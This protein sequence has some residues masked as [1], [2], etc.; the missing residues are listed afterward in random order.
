MSNLKTDVEQAVN[1]LKGEKRGGLFSTYI[2]FIQFPKYRNFQKDLRV[3][4]S[5]PL[6]VVVGQNGTGKSSLLQAMYGAPANLTPGQWWFGTALDPTS[7]EEITSGRQRLKPEDKGSFWYQYHNDGEMKQAVKMRIRRPGDPDYWEP[8]RPIKSFGMEIKEGKKRDPVI[9]M[10]AI[11]MNFKSQISAF[12]RC[13]YFNSPE[14]IKRVENSG[15]WKTILLSAKRRSARIQDYLRWRSHKL[16]RVLVGG[17]TVQHWNAD[18]H[19]PRV[20]LSQEELDDIGFI[21]GRRYTSG[22]LVEHRF[23]ETWGMSVMFNTDD[24]SYSDAF[25]G[26]GESAVVR[27]VREVYSSEPGRLLL[28]DEPETSLH[29]GAQERLL[30]FLLRKASEKKLQIVVSTHSPAFVRSLP[31]EAIRVLSLTGNGKVQ[32]AE[33][34]N[35]DEAFYVLGHPAENV[36]QLI[37]EDRLTKQLI[38][39]VL[40]TMEESFRSQFITDFRPGGE[41][42]IKQDA[43][44]FMLEP[45]VRRKLLFDGDK[46]ETVLKFERATIN[47]DHTS[48][49]IDELIKQHFGIKVKYRQNSQMSEDEKRGLR[50]AFIDFANDCFR[51]VPFDTPEDAIWSDDRAR[52]LLSLAGVDHEC[53]DEIESSK[54]AKEKFERLARL[55][56]PN[57]FDLTGGDIGTIHRVFIKAFC[58][59]SGE[60]V[61]SIVALLKE[62]ADGA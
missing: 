21:V 6:T 22:Y 30:L 42:A 61:V 10:D 54:S 26:S 51:C 58:Q 37:V 18:F 19:K 31:K 28:L 59:E 11:Y 44:L 39:A 45:E 16:K 60:I 13:F 7:E 48:D 38:D 25:A 32:V 41:S 29:P 50:F 4:F 9:A 1:R 24:L 12:D 49:E 14:A 40:E 8:S 36:T 62:I 15:Y 55:A 43:A 57:G 33:D 46:S 34:V 52:Q 3:T 53:F 47:I 2:D 23:Y 27:L 56:Q 20:V 17:E 5:F 35:A